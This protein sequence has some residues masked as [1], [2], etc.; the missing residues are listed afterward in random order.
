MATQTLASVPER[1]M[2]TV[3]EAVQRVGLPRTRVYAAI[4]A[5]DIFSVKVGRS[6]RIPARALEEYVARLCEEQSA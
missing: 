4:A 1:L 3:P 5:G 6:R 2:Y